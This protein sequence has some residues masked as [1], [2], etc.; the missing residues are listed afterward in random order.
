VISIAAPM[1]RIMQKRIF[2]DPNA[3]EGFASERQTLGAAQLILWLAVLVAGRLIAYS[4]TISARATERP[5]HNP[6]GRSDLPAAIRF[7]KGFG[8]PRSCRS[9]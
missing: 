8:D 6:A 7:V 4:F 5:T 1:M 2:D 3:S 9:F